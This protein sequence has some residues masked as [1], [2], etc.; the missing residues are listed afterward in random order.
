MEILYTVGTS[1]KVTERLC[2]SLLSAGTL[3][4]GFRPVKFFILLR[5]LV[6]LKKFMN[7]KFLIWLEVNYTPRKWF[8]SFIFDLFKIITSDHLI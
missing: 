6:I 8:R 3:S 1:L 4:K 7:V 5:K 2:L